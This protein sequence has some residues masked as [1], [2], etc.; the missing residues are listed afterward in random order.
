MRRDS[1]GRHGAV[2]VHADLSGLTSNTTYHVRLDAA[3][4]SGAA[5]GADATFT[6]AAVAPAVTVAP[7]AN[8]TGHGALLTG[9]V[10]PNN[11]T[12]TDCHFEYGT[13]TQYGTSVPCDQAVGG[14]ISP[15][16]VSATLSGLA[17]NTTYD[18]EL[19]AT[20]AGGTTRATGTF[21]TT[22]IDTTITSGPDGPDEQSG[23]D[24]HLHR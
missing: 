17:L 1:G 14:G 7:A 3:G 15:E 4:D 20:N 2:A 18:F 13:T 6:T 8:V 24:V 9:D 23:R 22:A 10:N 5:Q 21:D 12:V 16:P 11:A 19:V